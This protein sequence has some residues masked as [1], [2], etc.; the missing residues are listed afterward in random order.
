M[1]LQATSALTYNTYITQVALMT[2]VNVQKTGGV[3]VGVDD[4]FNNLIP[5]MLNY[6]E[7]RIQR[8]MDLTQSQV[9]DIEYSLTTGS[10][11]LPIDLNDFEILQ[12]F[13]LVVDQM[14]TPLLP[15]TKEFLQNI[16]PIGSTLGTPRYFAMSGGDA[17]TSGNTFQNV[18]VGPIP[19]LD[20][21]VILSGTRRMQTLYAY[22]VPVLAD[23]ATTYI[24]SQLPDMLVQASMIYVSQ[25][26]RNF[27][28]ASNDPQMGPSYEMQY[29]MLL[30]AASVEEARRRFQ[31]AA[32]TSQS[33]AVAAS[34]TRG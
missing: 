25:F 12:T 2:V 23:T 33:P 30:R 22:A 18:I 27:G 3:V 26:Q 31:A 1:P 10:R 15:V 6:A 8:D 5:Q 14:H 9:T 32:W 19:D 7:L 21:P 29:Q 28:P 4:A 16:H 24:S 11:Q 34:P 13:S 20:Y 17:T